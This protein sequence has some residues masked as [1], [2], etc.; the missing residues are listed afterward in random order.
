MKIRWICR[1]FKGKVDEEY[2][3]VS[4]FCEILC[5]VSHLVIS[6]IE[7][8]HTICS[9]SAKKVDRRS[10]ALSVTST[11]QCCRTEKPH[12]K[13]ENIQVFF[14]VCFYEQ[15]TEICTIKPNIAL[16]CC[17]CLWQEFPEIYFNFIENE[18]KMIEFC[19]QQRQFRQ[20][21][22]SMERAMLSSYTMGTSDGNSSSVIRL[23][24]MRIENSFSK[25][26]WRTFRT[27]SFKS[28]LNS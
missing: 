16:Y 11:V 12:Y 10:A 13:F 23:T 3:L 20:K 9:F 5:A 28:S 6:F 4:V 24:L 2:R 25:L 22:N 18:N 27:N 21:N 8:S 19:L 14:S 7:F 15:F 17:I 1:F 26:F